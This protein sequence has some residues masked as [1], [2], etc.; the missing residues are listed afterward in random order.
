MTEPTIA[1]PVCCECGV[2]L[3]MGP[4]QIQSAKGVPDWCVECAQFSDSL[5]SWGSSPAYDTH[6]PDEE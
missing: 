2:E 5:P 3:G 6:G 4:K 1:P